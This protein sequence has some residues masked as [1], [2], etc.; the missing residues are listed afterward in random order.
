MTNRIDHTNC[1]HPRTPAARRRCREGQ[2]QY[3]SIKT[4][5][6]LGI[7][8]HSDDEAVISTRVGRIR[9]GSIILAEV[10]GGMPE[11]Y[12][13]RSVSD[14]IKNDYPGWDAEGRWGYADQVL[15]VIK[16]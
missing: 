13:V 4:A 5:A 14:N 10:L 3:R 8:A 6:D 15:R 9:R 7:G 2:A 16:F 1:S 12:M 11:R